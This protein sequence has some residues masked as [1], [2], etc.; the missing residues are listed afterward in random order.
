M[1]GMEP[2]YIVSKGRQTH[3][4]DAGS[5]LSCWAVRELA[6]SLAELAGLFAMSPTAVGYAVDRGAIIATNI[7]YALSR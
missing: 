6:V 3:W 1:Y 4:I 5:L 2:S 7:R